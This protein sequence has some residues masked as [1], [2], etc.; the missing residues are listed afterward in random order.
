MGSLENE[1]APFARDALDL[2][3]ETVTI[4]NETYVGEDPNEGTFDWDDEA[5]F[6]VQGRVLENQRPMEEGENATQQ[7]TG[8][9]HVFVA[10]DTDVRDGRGDNQERASTI[11]D[12]DGNN[13]D[14]IRIT[15][16]H[17]GLIRCQC[18]M[19]GPGSAN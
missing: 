15:D 12:S 16:E 6:D 13:Y 10:S 19:E 2:F 3:G 5:P 7:V 8:E 11:V 9:Y 17:N 1:I 14:V 4:Q 18:T